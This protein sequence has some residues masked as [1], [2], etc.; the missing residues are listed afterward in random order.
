VLGQIRV[1]QVDPGT[2]GRIVVDGREMPAAQR[3][4][5]W[6]IR[7]DGYVGELTDPEGHPHPISLAE[8]ADADPETTWLQVILDHDQ[9]PRDDSE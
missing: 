3:L 4:S 7:L 1:E 8:W 6:L 9:S 2:V 5:D